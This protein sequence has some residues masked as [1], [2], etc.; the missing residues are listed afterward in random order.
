MRENVQL[1]TNRTPDGVG[2]TYVPFPPAPPLAFLHIPKTAGA[3]L[4][5]VL[6]SY[7]DAD[8][9]AEARN[10]PDFELLRGMSHHFR[11]FRGH[12][13]GSE[14]EF[15]PVGVQMFTLIRT[16][17]A[18]AASSYAYLRRYRETDW[19][20]AR[21]S[22]LSG[23]QIRGED[24]TEIARVA[25]TAALCRHHSVHEVIRMRDPAVSMSFHGML[26]RMLGGT[27]EALGLWDSLPPEH[28]A[29]PEL[30][31]DMASA[32]KACLQ[33][34]EVIGHSEN[35]GDALSL[36]CALRGWPAPPRTPR[37][38]DYGDNV[39]HKEMKSSDLM[40][41]FRSRNTA[42]YDV[43]AAGQVAVATLA[44]RIVD[45]F[46]VSSDRKTEINDRYRRRYFIEAPMCDGFDL[47]ASRAWGGCGWSLRE[48][49]GD[50]NAVRHFDDGRTASVLVRLE[51]APGGHLFR[52]Y[53]ANAASMTALESLT[54]ECAAGPLQRQSVG[55]LSSGHAMVEWRLTEAQRAAMGGD[56]EISLDLPQ[57]L[58]GVAMAFSRI[59]CLPL[60]QL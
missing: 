33:R 58:S 40:D 37:I 28:W 24:S 52:A 44:E 48:Y 16:P 36:I 2:A 43:Y 49:A 22:V 47:D 57:A 32:A 41:Y 53:I 19:E 21:A 9:I 50:R 8:D 54:A 7:F 3:S 25:R 12:F 17:E 10:P 35:L 5:A 38:H 59:A 55:H 4:I 56:V 1:G 51:P 45:Q 14:C 29:R 34:M 11:F 60:A 15:L 23:N 27:T 30:L 26:V 20:F 46:G 13:Y 31:R 39:T 18:I 42:D 6:D